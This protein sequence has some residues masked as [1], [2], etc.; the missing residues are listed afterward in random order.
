[1]KHVTL[2]FVK[3]IH[4]FLLKAHWGVIP[5]NHLWASHAPSMAAQCGW[6]PIDP[7]SFVIYTSFSTLSHHIISTRSPP[8]FFSFFCAY[9]VPPARYLFLREFQQ[10]LQDPT[11]SYS[12]PSKMNALLG[13]PTTFTLNSIIKLLW[14]SSPSSWPCWEQRTLF[15]LVLLCLADKKY[16]PL[17]YTWELLWSLCPL[18]IYHLFALWWENI[19]LYL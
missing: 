16:W 17:L 4:V 14:A 1:M 7:T 11:E 3:V 6:A 5:L 9:Q 13:F 18:P 10:T 15:L 8:L 2:L 12:R 19:Q